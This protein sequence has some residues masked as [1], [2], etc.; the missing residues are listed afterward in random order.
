MWAISTEDG[1][2]KWYRTSRDLL[3]PLLDDAH[4]VK[5]M[6]RTLDMTSLNRLNHLVGCIDSVE[7]LRRRPDHSNTDNQSPR[8]PPHVGKD[9]GVVDFPVH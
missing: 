6:R 1:S 2:L 9:E 4:D 7:E 3:S 8:L 5:M